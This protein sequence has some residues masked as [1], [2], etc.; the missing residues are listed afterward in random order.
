MK[1]TKQQALATSISSSKHDVTADGS[2]HVDVNL[3]VVRRTLCLVLME[4]I[5]Q[6]LVRKAIFS[7]SSTRRKKSMPRR[8]PPL[9]RNPFPCALN[10]FRIGGVEIEHHTTPF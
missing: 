3:D 2:G 6:F 8:C 9:I 1:H 4:R 10:D 7:L 5:D